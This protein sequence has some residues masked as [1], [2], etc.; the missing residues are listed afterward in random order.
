MILSILFRVSE[1]KTMS[2]AYAWTTLHMLSS[3]INLQY[4]SS[5]FRSDIFLIIGSIA[6]SK[7]N[8]DSEHPCQILFLILISD[9]DSPLFEIL[10]EIFSY[11]SHI[12]AI[13]DPGRFIFINMLR[14]SSWVIEPKAPWNRLL[15]EQSLLDLTASNRIEFAFRAWSKHHD[16]HGTK[17]FWFENTNPTFWYIWNMHIAI[18]VLI[19]P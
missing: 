12:K 19:S 9:V 7:I 16:V 11:G 13:K 4:L 8:D 1:N 5:L 6:K 15:N 2:S 10:V 14:I 17:P 3:P 18:L